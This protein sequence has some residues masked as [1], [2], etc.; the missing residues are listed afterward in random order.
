MTWMS[1]M[2]C[3]YAKEYK[4]SKVIYHNTKDCLQMTTCYSLYIQLLLLCPSFL[5]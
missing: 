5:H 1:S 3:K 4:K 2:T